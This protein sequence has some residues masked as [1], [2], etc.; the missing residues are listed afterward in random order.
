MKSD[1]WLTPPHIVEV[2]GIFDLDPCASINQPW[3]TA[4]KHF[5]INDDGLKKEWFGR[6]WLNPPFGREVEKWLSR[7]SE[8]GNGIAL[9][10]ARTETKCFYSFVWEKAD[11]VCFLR[12]RPHFYFPNGVRAPFNSG[13]P[14]ALIA[15]GLK[16]V[17]SLERA[18][19]GIV[20]K[21]RF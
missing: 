3:Q 1:D 10:A 17:R 11:A 8:H 7:L 19:L 2:L 14:I 21:W 13:A 4:T 16:N 15:Y 20:V 9:I 5:T 12:G 6:V 18:N